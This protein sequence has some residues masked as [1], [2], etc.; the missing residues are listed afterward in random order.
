MST[1]IQCKSNFLPAWFNIKT[2]NSA[3]AVQ[4][5][6]SELQWFSFKNVPTVTCKKKIDE[7]RN[8]DFIIS[9][10]IFGRK[11]TKQEYLTAPKLPFG[12]AVV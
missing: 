10:R 1:K 9:N 12:K 7:M 8:D 2:R 4:R 3:L 6:I 11:L 5:E